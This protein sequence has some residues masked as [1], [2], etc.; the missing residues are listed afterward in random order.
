MKKKFM[1]LIALLFVIFICLPEVGL[2]QADASEEKEQLN[3]KSIV[4]IVNES[5]NKNGKSYYGKATIRVINS[6]GAPSFKSSD[7]SIAKV[8]TNGVVTAVK[9]GKCNITVKVGKKKYT[10][11]VT[12]KNAYSQSSLKKNFKCTADIEDGVVRFKVINKYSHPMFVKINGDEIKADGSNISNSYE[13]YIPSKST[14][15]FYEELSSPISSFVFTCRTY[16]YTNGSRLGR[17]D[18]ERLIYSYTNDDFLTFSNAKLGFKITNVSI[19]PYESWGSTGI[20]VFIDGDFHNKTSIPISG[21]ARAL[22]DAYLLFYN[23]GELV[24]MVKVDTPYTYSGTEKMKLEHYKV[25]STDR[26]D[27]V[28]DDYKIVTNSKSLIMIRQ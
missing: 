16:G 20:E 18:P 12:V 4:L 8:E 5:K 3:R 28:Y 17:Q 26:W 14:S 19:E 9:A 25:Y 11:K 21:E 13:Y 27:G 6:T 10:C 23:K 2:V 22:A 1:T 7:E 15:Y 24:K